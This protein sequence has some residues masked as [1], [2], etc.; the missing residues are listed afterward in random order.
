MFEDVLARAQER[1]D[2]GVRLGVARQRDDAAARLSPEPATRG[3]AVS[4]DN[5]AASI[6]FTGDAK[7]RRRSRLRV[8]I[9]K[10]DGDKTEKRVT[11]L[12]QHVVVM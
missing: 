7:M 8:C 10:T 6:C 11:L 2:V 1:H 4:T 3:S 9:T 5:W 12:V